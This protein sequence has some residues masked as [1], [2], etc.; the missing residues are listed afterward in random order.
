MLWD[1][2]LN[3]RYIANVQIGKSQLERHSCYFAYT[4]PDEIAAE[5]MTHFI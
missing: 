5:H 2:I 3:K 4:N 1:A